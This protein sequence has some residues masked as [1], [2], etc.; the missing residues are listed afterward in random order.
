[1]YSFLLLLPGYQSDCISFSIFITPSKITPHHKSIEIS[2]F[3][4]H[5]KDCC[6]L[7]TDGSRM[8]NEVAA[9]V[10]YGN[11]TTTTRLPNNAGIFRAEYMLF[12]LHLLRFAVVNRKKL[13]S[14]RTTC[15]AW[16]L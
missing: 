14:F 7:Y 5:Y 2:L 12:Q 11:V 1:M 3:C 4:D 9:A 13:L 15:Q 10:I 8:G 6:R 16:K